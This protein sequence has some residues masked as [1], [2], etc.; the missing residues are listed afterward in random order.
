MLLDRPSLEMRA[1]LRDLIR[2]HDPNAA[3]AT[4]ELGTEAVEA[5]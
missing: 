4:H 2:A 5:A 3:A 1:K